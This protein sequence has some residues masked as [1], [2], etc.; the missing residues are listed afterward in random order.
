MD[1]LDDEGI[2]NEPRLFFRNVAA[3]PDVADI[4]EGDNIHRRRVLQVGS[5]VNR[6]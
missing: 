1:F 2:W 4:G 3:V 6:K 5:S